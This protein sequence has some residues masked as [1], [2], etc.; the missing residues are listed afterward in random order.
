MDQTTICNM[1]LQAAGLRDNIMDINENSNEAVKCRA[2]W[3]TTRDVLL[4]SAKWSFA[5]RTAALS[6][7]KTAGTG[8][9]TSDYPAPPWS[10]SYIIP[11][12]CIQPRYLIP[13]GTGAGGFNVPLFSVDLQVAPDVSGAPIKF[14]TATDTNAEGGSVRV[15]LTNQGS[16]ILVYTGR[17][18]DLTVWDPQFVDAFVLLLGA[19][20]AFALTGDR[21]LQ[22]DLAKQ[23]L[24]QAQSASL[25]DANEGITVHEITPDW[26]AVRG[27]G[28]FDLLPY[29]S[30]N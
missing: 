6:L 27:V 16:A 15:I 28:S 5:R 25:L 24:T 7:Y 21:G 30:V 12:D 18:E 23:A 8:P 10:Y 11:S 29:G 9:W 14:I 26:L 20:V 13:G 4:A 1:A 17:V 2:Q 19:R 22:M 3:D